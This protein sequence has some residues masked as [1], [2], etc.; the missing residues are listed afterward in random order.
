[1][2]TQR[3]RRHAAFNEP[4]GNC[5]LA[6]SSQARSDVRDSCMAETAFARQ[7]NISD[8]GA[9]QSGFSGVAGTK[10]IRLLGTGGSLLREEA[11][12]GCFIR[13]VPLSFTPLLCLPTN[14]T[15]LSTSAM[16]CESHSFHPVHGGTFPTFRLHY[17]QH[18]REGG[19]RLS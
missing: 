17:P 7:N 14:W 19:Y 16:L 8:P 15:K 2:N 6:V 13:R 10:A 3:V 18:L 12:L 4:P 5:L 9:L 11:A 1:M